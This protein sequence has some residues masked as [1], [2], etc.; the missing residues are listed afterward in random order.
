[1][2]DKI[3]IISF[4]IIIYGFAITLIILPKKTISN[5]ENR[6][7]K[8]FPEF[9]LTNDYSNSLDT[10]L[11]DHFP[12]RDNFLSLKAYYSYNILRKIENN[13][14]VI[15]K[16]QIYKMENTN[17]KSIDNY[18]DYI[19]KTMSYLNPN[20]KV[21]LVLIPDKNYYLDKKDFI[22][23]DYD[24]IYSKFDNLDINL[25]DVR[26]ILKSD[27]YYL[28]DTHLKQESLEDFIKY[29][30]K[31]LDITYKDIPYTYHYY[32]NFK[33]VYYKDIHIKSKLDTLTYLTNPYIDNCKVKYL[34]NSKLDK[35]YN[36]DKL[37]SRD[38]YE[39]YLDGA[40]SF[41]E[42]TNSNS[43]N[44]KELVIFRDSFGSSITPLLIPYYSKIIVIDN[45]YIAS[46]IYLNLIDFNK[47]DV[48][49]LNST[50]LVNQSFT[51]KK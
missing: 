23:I 19:T 1:M 41:I 51:L 11:L 48:L 38:S 6:Y 33:G 3:L 32:E 24:Y 34:E 30:L 28:T 12:L 46:K 45:R 21:S 25:I 15:N 47:Q 29:L 5:T 49:F 42:I 31:N 39:V 10:Y 26:N 22:K 2:K 9:K 18:Y 14:L 36:L 17:Y 20:N 35:V 50:L 16:A 37:D 44:D 7:L 13:N 8:E 4:L 40:S 27:D 43:L